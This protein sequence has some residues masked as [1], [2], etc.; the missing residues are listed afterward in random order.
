VVVE[1][2]GQH[3]GIC[4]SPMPGSH[5][6]IGGPLWAHHAVCPKIPGTLALVSICQD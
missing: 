1:I 3:V 5:T 2:A 6:K 4:G